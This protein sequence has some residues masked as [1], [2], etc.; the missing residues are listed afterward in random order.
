[1][2]A[3]CS[4]WRSRRV[5]AMM[6]I[7]RLL[8]TGIAIESVEVTVS[9]EFGAEGEPAKRVTYDA[10][11]VA[12][13]DQVEIRALMQRVDGLAEIQNTV[14]VAT[15]VVFAKVEA[16]SDRN[17]EESADV[18]NGFKMRL[19]PGNEAIYKEKHDQIWPELV[20]VLK[21]QGIVRLRDLPRWTRPLRPHRS[22]Q[23]PDT[24]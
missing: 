14:R 11:V 6:S 16:V 23:T 24:G 13:A 20:E 4:F 5:I 21:E 2:E 18:S 17:K 15:P 7:G 3:R 8:K 1:M 22:E 10:R 19:K 12:D 9:G